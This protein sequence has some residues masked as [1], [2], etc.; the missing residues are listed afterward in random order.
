M[1]LASL[2]FTTAGLSLL[3][4]GMTVIQTIAANPRRIYG[5]TLMHDHLHRREPFTELLRRAAQTNALL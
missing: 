3:Y 5:I 2:R 1:Q 4:L